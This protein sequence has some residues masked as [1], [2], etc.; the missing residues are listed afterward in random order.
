MKKRDKVVNA[1]TN[2][3]FVG[4][5]ILDKYKEHGIPT[6]GP[7]YKAFVYDAGK[8]LINAEGHDYKGYMDWLYSNEGNNLPQQS[9]GSI[10]T[11]LEDPDNFFNA[12]EGIANGT[13]EGYELNDDEISFFEDLYKALFK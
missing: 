13:D 2:M 12:L 3:L 1:I 8:I 11:A 5:T 6:E 10:Y 7:K 9:S 4:K